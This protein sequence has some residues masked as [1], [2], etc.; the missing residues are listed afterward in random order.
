M[1]N[2][3]NLLS[4]DRV[5]NVS[6][7]KLLLLLKRLSIF[8]LLVTAGTSLLFFALTL[9]PVLSN[10]KQQENTILQNLNFSQNKIAKYLFV[11][12][13][14]T[15]AEN[16]VNTRYPLDNV[17]LTI[18]QQLPQDAHIETIDIEGKVLNLKATSENLDSLNTIITNITN[19]LHDKKVFKS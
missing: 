7:Q 14:V 13:R 9:S 4:K 12:D 10:V 1:S 11:K 18:Q 16:I 19:L 5:Q 8:C 2:N 3:I 15:A 6:Q 17:V